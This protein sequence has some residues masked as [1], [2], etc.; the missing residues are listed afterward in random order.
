MAIQE[1]YVDPVSGTDSF[2]KGSVGDPYLTVQY[3]LNGLP[4]RDATDGDRVNIKDSGDDTMPV[5][6]L[7]L[8]SYGTPTQT[9]PLIFQGYTTAAGD[10]GIGGMAGNPGPI[11]NSTTLDYIMFIDLHLHTGGGSALIT[12]DNNI[13]FDNC[14]IDNTSGHGIDIDANGIV[15]NCYIHNCGGIGVN[16][17]AGA[18]RVVGCYFENGANK[19]D[20]AVVG[21]GTVMFNV[22]NLSSAANGSDGIRYADTALVA[23]N[24]IWSDA[25]V[26]AIGL[27]PLGTTM[28][29]TIIIN[30]II[31]GFSGSGGIGLQVTSD[32]ELFR[33]GYNA[34]YNNATAK[35][36]S[37]TM[38]DDQ[39]AN[40]TALGSSVFADPSSGDFS[41]DDTLA[42]GAF[43]MFRGGGV[44]TGTDQFLDLGGAQ[45]EE[46]EGGGDTIII[47]APIIVR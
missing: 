43:V 1:R 12:L 24:S 23:F 27:M 19:F 36:I 40:D 6:G 42:A 4:S 13:Q 33:V 15:E 44:D 41:I 10:G 7:S 34:F 47:P 25:G 32:D 31:E 28:H 37:G 17:F 29:D 22:I 11:F 16:V 21:G 3:A 9:A 30:N 18:A 38:K 14:E 5:A 8:A 46:P 2:G 26:N 35:S 45:R 20:A 39:T